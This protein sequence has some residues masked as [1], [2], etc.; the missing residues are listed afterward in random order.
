MKRQRGPKPELPINTAA[1]NP[2]GDLQARALFG[3]LLCA[4]TLLFGTGVFWASGQLIEAC[5]HTPVDWVSAVLMAVSLVAMVLV[6]RSLVWMSYFGAIMFATKKQAWRAQEVLCRSAIMLAKVIP[7]AASTASLVL[8][9]NLIGQNKSQEAITVAEE[10]WLRSTGPKGTVKPDQNVA[11]LCASAGLAHQLAGDV[12]ASIT[13]NERAIEA[14]RSVLDSVAKPKGLMAKLAA[15]QGSH[16]IG[17]VRLHLA[18]VH[19]HNANA[20]FG[21]M[22]YRAAKENFKRAIDNANQAPDSADKKEV[23]KVAKEQLARLKNA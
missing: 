16:W 10:Q 8:A 15:S 9:Q 2:I 1:S 18:V 23:L 11:L 7:G 4:S 13:W 17:P 6:A 3:G 22:N 21:T 20:H 19:L 5:K 14:F 12:R